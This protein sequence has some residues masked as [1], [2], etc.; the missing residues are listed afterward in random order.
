MDTTD[1]TRLAAENIALQGRIN[2]LTPYAI[3]GL[4]RAHPEPGSPAAELLAELTSDAGSPTP[5]P[6][7]LPLMISDMSEDLWCASWLVDCE[8]DLWARVE[9]YRR[10]GACDP[11]GLGSSDAVTSAI[12]LLSEASAATGTWAV[13]TKDGARTVSVDTWLAEYWPKAPRGA[14]TRAEQAPVC[15]EFGKMVLRENGRWPVLER[16][17]LTAGHAGEHQYTDGE[18]AHDANPANTPQ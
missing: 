1:L 4:R 8:Y 11:W 18:G 7:L 17:A 12:A 9:Q 15:G 6:A 3:A 5:L 10:T 13:D 14:L 16:C 2:T